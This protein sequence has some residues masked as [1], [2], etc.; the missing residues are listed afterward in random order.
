MWVGG[1]VREKRE[2]RYDQGTGIAS[3]TSGKN[4]G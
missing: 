2:F 3:G 4:E 1:D